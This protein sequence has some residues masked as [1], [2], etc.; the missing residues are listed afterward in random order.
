MAPTTLLIVE[1]L[2]TLFGHHA[3]QKSQNCCSQGRHSKFF[4]VDRPEIVEITGFRLGRAYHETCV[5]KENKSGRCT[6]EG[7]V[8][9]ASKL[10]TN[11][12][13]PET[14]LQPVDIG[15][16]FG[17]KPIQRSKEIPEKRKRT[18]I[19]D[20]SDEDFEATLQQLDEAPVTK[21]SK[22]VEKST[23]KKGK[24][25][26]PTK[27]EKMKSPAKEEKSKPALHLKM[28]KHLQKSQPGWNEEKDKRIK[29][30]L[31]ELDSNSNKTS[32]T[33]KSNKKM[34]AETTIVKETPKKKSSKDDDDDDPDVIDS[35]AFDAL[36]K[37]KEKA[38][39]YR[40]FL[41]SR[42]DGGAKN[43]GSKPV[44]EGAPG[45]LTGLT[46]VVTGVLES[47]HREEAEGLVKKYGGKAPKA[48]SKNTSYLL[49]GDDAGPS[50]LSKAKDLNVPMLS[51]DDFLK[52]IATRPAG[53]GLSSPAAKKAPTTPRSAHK[54]AASRKA[55]PEP[56]SKPITVS[57]P[58]KKKSP[59]PKKIDLK[60]QQSSSTAAPIRKAEPI[61]VK[62]EVAEGNDQAQL[63]WVDKYKPTSL[64]QVIGMHGDR[65]IAKKL[66]YWLK[67]WY[68]NRGKKLAKPSPWSTNDDG[69]FFKAALLS[70]PPGIGKTTTAHLAAKE[71][72]YDLV[73]M[74]ASDTRSKRLLHEHVMELL[75][76]QSLSSYA[77]GSAQIEGGR[78]RVLVMDEV[79]GMAGNED[80]GGI[81]ELIAMIKTSKIPVVCICNDRQHP[82]IRSLSNYCYD[83]KF[84]K[85][86][87]EQVRGAMMSICFKEGLSLKP[88]ALDEII[89]GANQDV[90]QVLHHLSMLASGKKS[91][92]TESA[93]LEASKSKKDLKL[94][95]WDVVKK[96]FSA[97]EH[98]GMSIHD[99]TGLFFQDYSFGPLF[100]QENYPCVVPQA[101][102]GNAI[103]TLD[104]LGRTAH[105]MSQTD[106]IEKVIR[107]QNA[108]S[109]L[110]VEAVFASVVPGQ[111][112]EGF[113]SSQIVF[114]SWL[115]KNS[116]TNKMDRLLQELQTHMRLKIS[117]S[118]RA[119]NLDYLPYVLNSIVG[120]L[121]R[122][123]AD[124][125]SEAIRAMES[126]D[127]MREDLDSLLEVA[128]WPHKPDIMAGIEGKV[129]A[130]FTRAYNK[131]AHMTPYAAGQV[132]K[133]RS[134]DTADDLEA[135]D[136]DEDG[137]AGEEDDEE[138]SQDPSLDA[139]IKVKKESKKTA[140]SSS[141]SGATAAASR[142][143]T[144]AP[145]A[146]R[147]RGR[148][149]RKKAAE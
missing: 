52:L 85:P 90:R 2:E 11:A 89:M 82:K 120:P 26:S 118:K 67:S 144:G 107:S 12:K 149:G 44:P 5:L 1:S 22:V 4:H 123:G 104:L 137:L 140:S 7:A 78:K 128:Q 38:E 40:K 57:S 95:P 25:D 134:K 135:L 65:S 98:K 102:K 83:L 31:K 111:L 121:K 56:P 94:G 20:H 91:L 72:G 108:W 9:S 75:S 116:R 42:R 86:K 17:N 145:A 18:V 79:D 3:S 19:E 88:E 73:E 28:R 24:T 27:K 39:N 142:K 103:K 132:K 115:G 33:P 41:A 54:A 10:K 114:P 130:A 62:M 109:L 63:P 59:E 133:G 97:E 126:Y 141:S 35:P 45:C 14:P 66:V 70:G 101:A 76:S 106:L 87:I 117:G 8:V 139:M 77:H 43:P 55:E 49:A 50:K 99:K 51:E 15:S 68:D 61:S 138:Q 81:Q 74:N 34:K 80:R 110:P 13:T 32:S 30:Q 48:V 105:C 47:L 147:G 93:K 92:S 136:G 84:T 119:V 60:P 113:I 46:I 36:E 69:A 6:K 64:K 71:L 100:V 53:Q 21:K 58:P 122:S 143:K 29:S 124:G 125:V 112:M 23:S 129:K 127:L 146:T 16:V 131:E 96:V 37:R 148:G